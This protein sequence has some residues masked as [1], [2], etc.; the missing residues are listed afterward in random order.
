M[1]TQR[2]APKDAKITRE[3]EGNT[4]EQLLELGLSKKA[5]QRLLAQQETPNDIWDLLKRFYVCKW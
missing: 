3:H 2:F 4:P 1:K 5:Y